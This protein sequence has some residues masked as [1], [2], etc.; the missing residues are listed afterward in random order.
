MSGGKPLSN[1]YAK[2]IGNLSVI[3]ESMGR[4]SQQRISNT[5]RAFNLAATNSFKKRAKATGGQLTLNGGT[6]FDP[7]KPTGSLR[8]A[9]KDPS[10]AQSRTGY[11]ITYGGCPITWGSRLQRE[12][13]LSSTEAE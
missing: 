4:Q 7:R 12:V 11:I 5:K 13:A 10:V 1:P 8:S 6:A 2:G 9:D 3:N